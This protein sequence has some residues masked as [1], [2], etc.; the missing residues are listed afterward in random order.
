MINREKINYSPERVNVNVKVN[1]AGARETFET[2]CV[3]SS[4]TD[5]LLTSE[6]RPMLK[7]KNKK[8]HQIVCLSVLIVRINCTIDKSDFSQK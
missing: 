5:N 8:S 1:S 2:N 3:A 7:I 4:H 6:P